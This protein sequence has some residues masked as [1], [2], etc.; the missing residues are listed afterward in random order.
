MGHSYQVFYYC[1]SSE[2]Y[3]F[4]GM[5][6]FESYLLLDKEFVDRSVIS[7]KIIRIHPPFGVET[8]IADK[9]KRVNDRTIREVLERVAKWR[10]IHSSR[11]VTLEEASKEVHLP[12]KT[13]D[14]YFYQIKQGEEYG[15]D[16]EHNLSKRIGVLRKFV[17]E[18]HTKKEEKPLKIIEQFMHEEEMS[19]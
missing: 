8:T 2:Y 19:D 1:N 14:D 17:K 5:Y 15:F 11:G 10:S 18:N 13:L 6:P 9:K 16:F 12:K 3:V 7:V 4:G